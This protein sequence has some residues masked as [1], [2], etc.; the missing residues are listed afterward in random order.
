MKA[1]LDKVIIVRNA[2]NTIQ[3]IVIH[4][5]KSQKKTFYM[6]EEMSMD[7]ILEMFNEK[8]SSN[9]LQTSVGEV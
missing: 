3:A 8:F 1:E 5:T 9:D 6:V 7:D 4:D 2:E